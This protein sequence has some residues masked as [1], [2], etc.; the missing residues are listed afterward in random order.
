[1]AA[2]PL[3]ADQVGLPHFEVPPDDGT[4]PDIFR[5]GSHRRAAEAL[6]FGIEVHALGFNL[7]VIGEDRSGRMTATLA[8]LDSL[9]QT[10]PAPSDWLYLGGFT[11]GAPA[12]AHRLPAGVGR[13]FA[14]RVAAVVAML[15]VLL[16]DAFAGEAYQTQIQAIR[17]ASQ[18]EMARTVDG[19]RAEAVGLGYDLAQ[20]RDGL[21]LVPLVAGGAGSAPAAAPSAEVERQ[22]TAALARI[23][24]VAAQIRAAIAERVGELDRTVAEQVAAA[25]LEAL[26]EEFS[27]FGGLARWLTEMRVD[28]LAAPGR[29]RL[30]EADSVGAELPERRYAVN[31]LV[32]RGHDRHPSVI[33]DSHPTYENLF[34]RIEYRQTAGAVQTDFAMIRAGSLHRANGGVL[35]LR[36]EALA[37]Q[38]EVWEFLKAALRDRAIRIEE[39]Q[40]SQTL[41]IEGAPRPQPIPLDAKVVIVGAP[42]WYQTFFAGDPDFQTYFKVKAD[43]D[44]DMAATPE[45]IRTYAQ[46][47][48]AWARAA[49]PAAI[50]DAAVGRLLAQAAR[51]AERRDRLTAR[52]EMI[53][54]LVAE[55]A[56][57]ARRRGEHAVT[58]AAVN[59]A[60]VARRRRGSRIED[61]LHESI[62][63]G[64]VMIAV[65]GSRLGQVNALT[66][67]DVGDRQFGT[68]ARVTASASVG[69]S[70]VINIERDAALGGPIQQKGAMVLQGFLA[71]RFA[72]AHPL[73]FTCSITFEQSYGG[74]EGDSASLAE[75]VAVLSALSG[76]PVRQDLAITGSVDQHGRAQAI[77][78]AHWKVEGFHR[79]CRS[80]P[81][82]LTGSQGVLIPAVNSVNLVLY[83]EV[84]ADVAAGRFGLWS[85]ASVE[86]AAELMLGTPAGTPD[87]GGRYP[88]DSIYGRV[89]ATLAGFDRLL[90][91][92]ERASLP[93]R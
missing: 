89:A 91:E 20:G 7:F 50:D 31:L 41:P 61:R 24:A 15:R 1:M 2:I 34:G 77:G 57:H 11:S 83:G 35:V 36:A 37:G 80:L 65:A 21:K 16:A 79:V 19:V 52:F 58:V 66:V 90:A 32:D 53:E 30:T 54:D 47:I 71:G 23:Q 3:E 69:R 68:P 46:M 6:E 86:D 72:R 27:G 75:L 55:A 10:R 88:P 25:P 93:G 59:A 9:M 81:G 56:I 26:A 8:K 33:L 60:I 12:T 62:A 39:P 82:G 76:L 38:P 70:G 67:R 74:V 44:P 14:E 49:E 48:R 42:R 87:A 92:R 85:V 18:G 28:V 78:G 43:I 13:R 73:S 45:D 40:R 5:L 29:F 84:A 22:L 64:Q 63:E 4:P 17:D 51:Q